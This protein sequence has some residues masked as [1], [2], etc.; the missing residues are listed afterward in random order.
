MGDVSVCFGCPVQIHVTDL[1]PVATIDAT[2]DIPSVKCVETN[3]E[4]A[5]KAGAPV[6]ID[7]L[8]T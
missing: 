5:S 4:R 1:M 7:I 2:A 8:W 3:V 6:A